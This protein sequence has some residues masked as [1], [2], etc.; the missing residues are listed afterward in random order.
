MLQAAA[1]I[2]SHYSLMTTNG[3]SKLHPTENLEPEVLPVP[4]E[5]TTAWGSG[6]PSHTCPAVPLQMIGQP[7][8]P[9]PSINRCSLERLQAPFRCPAPV[10]WQIGWPDSK[11]PSLSSLFRPSLQDEVGSGDIIKAV[12]RHCRRK[13]QNWA[14]RKAPNWHTAPQGHTRMHMHTHA[15]THPGAMVCG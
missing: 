13:G 2:G 15:H 7:G 1:H 8:P 12:H 3:F 6:R 5:A 11:P 9:R 14:K 10:P 4:S